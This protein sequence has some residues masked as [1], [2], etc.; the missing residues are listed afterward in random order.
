MGNALGIVHPVDAQAHQFALQ[1]PLRPQPRHFRSDFR[2]FRKA[3][4]IVKVNADGKGAHQGGF[5]L[6]LNAVIFGIH[7]ERQGPG[8]GVHKVVAVGADVKAQQIVAQQPGHQFILP[9]TDAENFG[10]RPGNVP[11]LAGDG[12]RGHAADVLRQQGQVI[13]LGQHNGRPTA[14]FV[15]HQV[16]ELAIDRL[17]GLPVPPVKNRL[18][19]GIVAQRPQGLVGKAIVIALLLLRG[20]P[21]QPQGISRIL[22]RHHNPIVPIHYIAV[23][24]AAAVGNPGAAARLH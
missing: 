16:G 21:D 15:Q 19:I 1:P 24:A 8:G 9:G 6:I 23:A 7:L 20:Q 11:E 3:G 10:M 12:V 17:I 2:A 5:P 4:K 13:I 18:G 14:D 22:R